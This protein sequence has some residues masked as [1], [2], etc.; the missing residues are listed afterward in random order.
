MLLWSTSLRVRGAVLRAPVW[1][2]RRRDQERRPGADWYGQQ[3][4]S[5]AGRLPGAVERPAVE[6]TGVRGRGAWRLPRPRPVAEDASADPA[7]ASC[8]SRPDTSPDDRPDPGDQLLGHDA[9]L[10]GRAGARS[11]PRRPRARRRRT[12][13]SAGPAAPPPRTRLGR[14]RPR[15]RTA[16][17]GRPPYRGPSRPP[18]RGRRSRDRARSSPDGRPASTPADGPETDGRR[19]RRAPFDRAGPR[20]RPDLDAD[21]RPAPEPV[22]AVAADPRR[23]PPAGDRARHRPRRSHRRPGHRARRPARSS[24]AGPTALAMD[25]TVTVTVDGQDR[26]VHTFAGDVAGALAAAG[27][28]AAPQDRVEPA[29]PTALA[30]GDH[31]IVSRA[32][33]L[34][35]DRGRRRAARSGPRRRSVG[36]ALAGL[37]V[38]SPPIQMSASPDAAD[39]AGRARAGAAGAA[40]GHA[41]RRHRRPDPV[42]TTAGTVAGLLAE[43]GIALGPDDVVRPRRRHPAHRRHGRAGRPQRRRRGR[44]DARRIAPPDQKIEDPDDAARQGGRGRPGQARRAD[45]DHAGLRAERRGGPPR[46]GRGPAPST[47]AVPRVVRVG[48]NDDESA[49]A[50]ARPSVRRQRLGPARQVRGH[51]QLGASTP[52]TATTAACSSTRGT[53]RAYGGDAVRGAAAPGQPRGADRGR[54]QGARRPRR[55]RRLA[56]LL[57]QA[58]PAPVTSTTGRRADPAVPAWVH[59]VTLPGERRAAARPRRGARAGR[60]SWACGRPNGWARTSCT[61][62]TRCGASCGPPS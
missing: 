40:H 25:K 47:A 1:A 7:T 21:H 10:P 41:H 56:G 26:T 22:P 37:G 55:L 32:R 48:T 28:S 17:T 46:A 6:S 27:I 5:D 20:H 53:W 12:T 38:E 18:S 24:A 44:R 19:A 23:G 57:A 15:R 42:T 11:R 58:R 31:V 52:A 43:H 39:P 8:R 51:R 29:L 50:A 62:R 4:F 14:R 36:D 13:S 3:R 61:T 33:P 54:R 49:V 30:D 2:L 59:G 34:T 9:A 60:A 45:R 16:A 35:L